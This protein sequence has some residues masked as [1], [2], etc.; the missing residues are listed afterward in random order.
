MNE[1]G[2]YLYGCEL[3]AITSAAISTCDWLDGVV[4]G[5]I[6]RVYDCLDAF[7]P[8]SVVVTAIKCAQTNGTKVRVSEAAAFVANVTWNGRVENGKHVYHGIDPGSDLSGSDTSIGGSIALAM[9]NC[10][11]RPVPV[12]LSLLAR[13]GFSYLGPKTR[14]WTCQTSPV[15]SLMQL[16]DRRHS[17]MLL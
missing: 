2:Q 1:L 5:T 13:S 8:F 14:N 9:T 4:D 15:L 3:D 11:G 16:P 12:S 17:S 7:D 10:T 6:A